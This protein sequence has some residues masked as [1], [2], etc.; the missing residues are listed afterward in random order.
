MKKL[1]LLL[2]IALGLGSVSCTSETHDASAPH[3]SEPSILTSEHEVQTRDDEINEA[4]LKRALQQR[5]NRLNSSTLLAVVD[6]ETRYNE[7]FIPTVYFEVK[8]N[9]EST[10][11]AFEMRADGLN[12]FTKRFKT[13]I[14]PSQRFSASFQADELKGSSGDIAISVSKVIFSDGQMVEITK[15]TW[16][17]VK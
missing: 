11:I 4:E 3:L 12:E 14:P 6:T 17:H 16:E 1:L 13:K 5:S 10:I 15:P 7:D 2:S 9:T 8:N